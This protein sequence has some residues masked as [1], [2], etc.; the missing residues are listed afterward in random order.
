MRWKGLIFIAAILGIV[1]VLS[2]FFTD[3]WLERRL[4]N[5]GSSIVGAKVEIDHL[6]FSLIGVHLRWDS[7]QVADPKDT[8]KNLLTTGRT[9]FNME[10][11]PLLAKKYILENF[12][13]SRMGSGSKRTTDGK[14]EKHK[15]KPA[16]P[17]FFSKTIQKLEN[18]VSRAPAWNLGQYKSKVNVDSL[19]ALLDLQSP[20]KIDSLKKDLQAKYAHWDSVFT[21]VAFDQDFRALETRIKSMNPAEIKT[22]E[23][24]QAALNTVKQAK[25][26]VDSLQKAVSETRT[27]FTADLENFQNS[28][29]RADDWIKEDYENALTKAK[30]PDI[31]RQNIGKFIF[32][33][34]IVYQLNRILSIT[35]TVRKYAAKFQ[36]DKPKKEKP[37]R[38]KGQNIHFVQKNAKPEFWAR[39]IHLSGKTQEGLSFAGELDNLVSSQRLIGK[40]TTITIKGSRADG[41]ALNVN[42][43]FNYL[44]E[45]PREAFSLK[46]KKIPLN[47]VKL[48]DSPL[49]PNKVRSGVGSI[50]AELEIT[51]EQLRSQIKFSADNL[52]F[53]ALANEGELN[54]LEKN[55]QKVIRSAS[56]IDLDA[57]IKSENNDLAFSVHSNLDDLFAQQ[58]QSALSA[59]VGK[60]K[61]KVRANVNKRV[62]KYRDDLQS[63]VGER[64]AKLEGLMKNYEK[65]AAEKSRLVDD[66]KKELE[67]RINQEKKKGTQKLQ[68]QIKKRFKGFNP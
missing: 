62:Q 45:V 39:K 41:S 47:N 55:V 17:G 5:A 7:L 40:T 6:D 52:K 12:E 24:L 66:K 56:T 25:S 38:L 63:F 26:K 64:Q 59:E 53:A 29:K 27:H 36:S 57:D 37:P 19:V 22:P 21:N 31:N 16:K 54:A 20:Q 28:L 11:L 33:S 9:E 1:F 14:I 67:A 23:G 51:G 50:N 32:G 8:W 49:L 68:D 61:Q 4:E 42:G 10:F 43:E 44:D 60:A 65:M 46:M 48:A 34:K 3:A 2:L 58:L 35:A 18:D 30:L 13:I 15:K